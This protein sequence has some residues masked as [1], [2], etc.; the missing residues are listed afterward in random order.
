MM[1][2]NKRRRRSETGEER[3]Q[4]VFQSSGDVIKMLTPSSQT[5]HD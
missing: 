4:D 2:A 5:R 1:K 3:G